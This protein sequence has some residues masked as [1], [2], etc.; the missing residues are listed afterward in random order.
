MSISNITFTIMIIIIVIQA[1]TIHG[2]GRSNKMHKFVLARLQALVSEYIPML[3]KDM[4]VGDRQAFRGD[5][6][7]LLHKLGTIEPFDA[8]K[9]NTK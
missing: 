8:F 6:K 5:G 2:L 3:I 1:F 4:V 9:K 7:E